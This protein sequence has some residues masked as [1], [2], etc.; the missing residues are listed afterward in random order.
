MWQA[1]AAKKSKLAPRLQETEVKK[2]VKTLQAQIEQGTTAQ[3]RTALKRLENLLVQL[4][5]EEE[6]ESDHDE[7]VKGKGGLGFEPGQVAPD[8]VLKDQVGRYSPGF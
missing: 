3:R 5:A 6:L 8:F 7:D 2:L 4:K 1:P